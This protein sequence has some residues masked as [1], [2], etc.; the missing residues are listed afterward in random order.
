[1]LN[2][3]GLK[4]DPCLTSFLIGM[5]SEP[6]PWFQI[7]TKASLYESIIVL[8]THKGKSAFFFKFC[9]KMS[10]IIDPKASLQSIAAIYMSFLFVIS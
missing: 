5:G 2:N 10:R 8:T 9:S 4:E 1:M 7:L 3:D 6:S